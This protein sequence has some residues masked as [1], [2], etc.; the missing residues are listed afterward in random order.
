MNHYKAVVVDVDGTITERDRKLHLGATWALRQIPLPVVLASGNT[1]CFMGA[2]SVLVGTSRVMI[3][4]NGGVVKE[5]LDG[6]LILNGDLERCEEAYRV[7][8]QE[9]DLEKLDAGNRYTE[10]ALRRDFDVG[11]AQ[12][13]LAAHD[14]P[15]LELVDT[16]YAVHIKQKNV[17]KGLGLGVA[18]D[19]MG[20]S[21]GDFLAVGDS[22]NDVA[23][24][25]AAGYGVAVANASPRL[26]E[27]ADMVTR[28]S[29]GDGLVEAFERLG[30]LS[31]GLVG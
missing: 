18:A 5:E 9:F 14:F 26:K 22:D 28:E 19:L 3:G 4:E 23:L 10:I 21:P 6:D 1:I 7:L 2:A 31:E 27:A 11:A 24:L 15:G 13:V 25:G 16:G 29:Y 8:S 20:L 12:E 30:L 17:D